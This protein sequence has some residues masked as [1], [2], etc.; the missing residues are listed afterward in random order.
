MERVISDCDCLFSAAEYEGKTV[1]PGGSMTL[2]FRL[3]LGVQ[4]RELLR[5]I[6]IRLASGE[7]IPVTAHARVVAT[8][9][10]STGL[11]AFGDVPLLGGEHA[12]KSVRFTSSTVQ[13]VDA[14]GDR[15]WVHAEVSP[16]GPHESEVVITLLSER[17]PSGTNSANVVLATDDP[18]R[19]QS[20]VRVTATGIAE[21]RPYPAQVI[22]P[23]QEAMAV[24]V[25]RRDGQPAMLK[26]ATCEQPEID[27]SIDA[28]GRLQVRN[29]G[30]RGG[31]A[32]VVLEDRDGR[33][34]VLLVLCIPPHADSP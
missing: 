17:L 31:T 18:R 11:I 26:S 14:R 28:D 27:A 16:L 33:R 22:V 24:K 32:R 21:L 12:A 1:A 20:A 9:S 3:R 25:F 2:Q 15:E 4:A 8:Y 29:G 23:A 30:L 13:L 10:L 6:E 5:H 19:P 34:G 7:R